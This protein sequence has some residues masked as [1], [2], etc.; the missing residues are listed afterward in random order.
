MPFVGF[1]E[2]SVAGLVLQAIDML[3]KEAAPQAVEDQARSLLLQLATADGIARLPFTSLAHLAESTFAD[4]LVGSEEEEAKVGLLGLL[5]TRL[6][7]ANT[8]ERVQL[9]QVS[10]TGR[11][12]ASD[13]AQT[14][15]E[16]LGRR[17]HM[18]SLHQFQTEDQFSHEV[19]SFLETGGQE[20]SCLIVQCGAAADMGEL[21]ACAKQC[22]QTSVCAAEG[23][24]RDNEVAPAAVAV[25]LLLRVC[26]FGDVGGKG[27]AGNSGR[28]AWA[29]SQGAGQ[30][31]LCFH[32][33]ELLQEPGLQ[34][35]HMQH[36]SV[37]EAVEADFERVLACS[38]VPACS[39]LR[40]AERGAGP[41]IPQ[42]RGAQRVDM[43]MRLGRDAGVIDAFRC[44]LLELLREA[45]QTMMD[46]RG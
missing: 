34:L 20:P 3:G 42:L 28:L 36:R 15:G 25:V 35:S 23:C 27:E 31:W 33:D 1:Q 8:S 38:W 26:V 39:R 37:V 5:R 29:C 46:P 22:I 12:L 4:R 43:L 30:R 19:R 16:K 44:R 2:D 18:L 32:L 13:E 24:R 14:L 41:F 9:F 7:A 45:E 21:I 10:T 6:L 40:E 11:L 17:F